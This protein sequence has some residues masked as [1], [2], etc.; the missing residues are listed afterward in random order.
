MKGPIVCDISGTVLTEAD[1]RRIAHPLVGMVI[2]FSRNYESRRQ[3]RNLCDAIHDVKP[4]ILI[5]VDHE[6]GRVQRFRNEFTQIPAMSLYGKAFAK[7]KVKALTSLEEA[8]FVLAA[9]LRECGTDFT[10]APVLDL[11]WN[12]STIIGERS[13]SRDPKDVALMARAVCTG[14]ARAGVANC[15]KHFPGHGYASAD[16]HVSLP[17]DERSAEE[18]LLNDVEPYR[19]L[20]GVL[21]SIMTAHVLYPALDG[22]PATFSRKII[23]DILRKKIGF[24]GLLFSDDL[25]MQGAKG[26]G[27]IL[28]RAEK[29]FSAG[30][31]AII[32]CNAPES[33]DVLLENLVWKETSQFLQRASLIC[34]RGKLWH[35]GELQDCDEYKNALSR[36]QDGL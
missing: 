35:F 20:L 31:D 6:G 27:D 15:A 30:C 21:K 2:L 14:F 19:E 3:L 16:S 25:S 34:P 22:V 4:E 5:G 9:E 11:N 32:V 8:A 33:V 13:F 24:D 1:C 10:F 17:V 29:A 18:I 36:M 7:D 26:E 23:T 28:Q 12:R